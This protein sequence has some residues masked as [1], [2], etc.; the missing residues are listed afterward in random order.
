VSIPALDLEAEDPYPDDDRAAATIE[1]MLKHHRDVEACFSSILSLRRCPYDEET[2]EVRSF[3][4]LVI[5]S[6]KIRNVGS[7]PLLLDF[8][9]RGLYRDME[10]D[11]WGELPTVEVPVDY[12][13]LNL[14][15]V[16]VENVYSCRYC[17]YYSHRDDRILRHVRDKHPQIDGPFCI[18]REEA[19]I[20][21]ESAVEGGSV[22]M[23]LSEFETVE[24]ESP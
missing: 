17:G 12:K 5:E 9:K 6:A 8:E 22:P 16:L 2:G 24:G 20:V 7:P 15:K 10:I 23:T 11:D 3:F 18:A 21:D 1:A 4:D 14:P 13:R 19:D